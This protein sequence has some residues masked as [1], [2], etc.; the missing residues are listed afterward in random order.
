MKSVKMI[1]GIAWEYAKVCYQVSRSG[2]DRENISEKEAELLSSFRPYTK[3]YRFLKTLLVG[4]REYWE[5]DKRE[6][7]PRSVK[8]IPSLSAPNP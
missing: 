8:N 2:A 4:I 5:A 3:E 1:M 6:T 7:A